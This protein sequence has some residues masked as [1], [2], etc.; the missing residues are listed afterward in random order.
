[1][2]IPRGATGRARDIMHAL[3]WMVRLMVT[4]LSVAASVAALAGGKAFSSTQM[5]ETKENLAIK[6]IYLGK[7]YPEP[8]SLSLM[9]TVPADN[10]VAGAR[11]ATQEINVTGSFLGLQYDLDVEILPADG[12]VIARAKQAFSANHTLVVADLSPADLLAVADLPEAA[13]A[14]ILDLRTIDDSLRQENCR[15]NV[16]HLLPSRAMRADALA[17]F[18]VI[19]HWLRWFLMK[20]SHANDEAYANDIRRAAVRFGGKI[21]EERLY[22]YDPGARRVD[23][24][25]QQI[26]TQMPLVTQTSASHDVLVVA[27]EDDQFGDYLPYNTSDARPVVGTQGL[28]ATAWHPSFQEYSALQMQYRFKRSAHRFMTERDYA[29]WLAVRIVGEAVVRSGKTDSMSLRNFMKSDRFGVAGFKGEAM[30]FRKWDQQL[31]QPVLLAQPL[32]VTSI[33]PQGGFLHPKFLTDTL[34]FDEPETKCHFPN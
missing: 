28:V 6:I 16:F 3:P 23:T 34:G 30:T 9:Q 5:P 4:A 24:G 12:D 32:M 10:G 13:D 19:K 15:A 29:G 26:Q 25:F 7:T 18:L 27:D 1:M 22:S 20:G 8:E 21:V 33:S 2:G 14:I 11:L 31:R 17:Q